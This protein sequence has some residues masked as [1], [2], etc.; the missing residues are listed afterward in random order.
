MTIRT[1]R[2]IDF[3]ILF[4]NVAQ[5]LANN[6]VRFGCPACLPS[7]KSTSLEEYIAKAVELEA[8][9]AHAADPELKAT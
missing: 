5:V 2:V 6:L 3:P 8:R 7:S 9:A 1:S 4:R